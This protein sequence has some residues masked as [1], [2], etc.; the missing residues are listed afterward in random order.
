M[1]PD[2]PKIIIIA[3]CHPI[4]FA[5]SSDIQSPREMVVMVDDMDYLTPIKPASI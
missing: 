2:T 1:M 5:E 3:S 4:F